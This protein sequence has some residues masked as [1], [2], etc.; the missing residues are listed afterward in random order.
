[1]LFGQLEDRIANRGVGRGRQ[2]K[3]ATVRL[4]SKRVDRVRKSTTLRAG[5]LTDCRPKA[6]AASL[7]GERYLEGVMANSGWKMTATLT[8]R[9]AASFSNP[10]HL[11]TIEGSK[12]LKPVILPSGRAIFRTRPAPTGSGPVKMIGIFRVCCRSAPVG[13]PPNAKIKSGAQRTK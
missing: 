4:G 6:D 13:C 8:R 12:I 3:K 7:I 1:M 2:D 9:G 11:P 5:V 10:S